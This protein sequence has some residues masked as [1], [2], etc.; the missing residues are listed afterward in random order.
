MAASRERAAAFLS[1]CLSLQK[2]CSIGFRSAEYYGSKKAFAPASR[3]TRPHSL[4]A[5]AAECRFLAL[6]PNSRLRRELRL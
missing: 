4:A 5:M 1:P 3:V 2:T 6:F